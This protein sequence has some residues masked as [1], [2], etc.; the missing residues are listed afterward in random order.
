[1]E[2]GTMDQEGDDGKGAL[3]QEYE[4]GKVDIGTE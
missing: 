4:D 3:E 1:M 2:R